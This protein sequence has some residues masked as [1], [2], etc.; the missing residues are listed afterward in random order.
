MKVLRW[1]KS[2]IYYFSFALVLAG[3][4]TA[5]AWG[6][7]NFSFYGQPRGGVDEGPSL[8][9]QTEASL[10]PS[11]PG[12]ST[13]PAVNPEDDYY[14]DAN[15]NWIAGTPPPGEVEPKTSSWCVE[16]KRKKWQNSHCGEVHCL[17]GRSG[18][19]ADW[20]ER[21]DGCSSNLQRYVCLDQRESRDLD[22]AD[23]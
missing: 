6:S 23:D 7:N 3:V 11:S 4:S 22:S 2:N 18:P 20:F 16:K 9:V 13:P 12:P 14:I 8:T 5:S 10:Q 17:D 19:R 21:C 1:F 15:G